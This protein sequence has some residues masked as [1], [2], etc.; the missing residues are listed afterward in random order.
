MTFI[1]IDNLCNIDFRLQ[2]TSSW[3]SEMV[4]LSVAESLS[5]AAFLEIT[6]TP[7]DKLAMPT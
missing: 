2:P 4:K 3:A 7:F 6:L 1:W 5:T